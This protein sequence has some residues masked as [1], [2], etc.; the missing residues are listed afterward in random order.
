MRADRLMAIL[1]HLQAHGRT[2]AAELAER[3]EVSERTIYRDLDA[4]SLAGV[5]VYAERGPGGG[6]ALPDDYRTNLTA[7][8]E[9]EV[10]TIFMS[11]LRG[12]LQELGLDRALD[13]ALS[14]LQAALPANHQQ[15]ALISR[16]RVYFDAASWNR[17]N[18]TVPYIRELQEAVWQ[19]RRV[20]LNHHK[21]DGKA[22]ERLVEPYGLVA[23]A[24]IWYLVAGTLSSDDQK[25]FR[26]SVYRASRILGVRFTDDH[27]ERPQDF[28]LGAYWD[29]WCANYKAS[30]YIYPVTIKFHESATRALHQAFGETIFEAIRKAQPA[31]NGM[32]TVKLLFEYHEDARNNLIRLGTLVEVLEPLELRDSIYELAQSLA[33]F[34]TPHQ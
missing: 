22:N 21:G 14:K 28:D 20:W 33:N 34:Y 30:W 7:L 19:Q 29:E 16:Q 1:L 13:D 17:P 26:V 32:L 4:L 24:S 12:P 25:G 9:A 31:E 5:P 8:N 15:D 23:K 6:C 27:F 10:R 18:E 3:L 2:T 11:G